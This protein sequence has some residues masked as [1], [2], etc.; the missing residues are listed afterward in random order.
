[1]TTNKEKRKALE[2]I[3][4]VP[5]G[6]FWELSDEA[7]DQEYFRIFQADSNDNQK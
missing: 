3:Y 7:I 1:M 4:G 6:E 2:D 5:H